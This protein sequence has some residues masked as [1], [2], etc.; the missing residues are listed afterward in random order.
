MRIFEDYDEDFVDFDFDLGEFGDFFWG[1]WGL[2]WGLRGWWKEEDDKDQRQWSVRKTQPKKR[3]QGKCPLNIEIRLWWSSWSLWFKFMM[4][5]MMTAIDIHRSRVWHKNEIK[6]QWVSEN[7]LRR[8]PIRW[9]RHNCKQSPILTIKRC[10]RRNEMVGVGKRRRWGAMCE[11]LSTE[12]VGTNNS[13]SIFTS[14]PPQSTLPRA[15]QPG[16]RKK[17]PSYAL[18]PTIFLLIGLWT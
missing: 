3:C 15:G 6:D 18:A 8:V 11:H 5:M 12:N 2:W 1:L 9:N 10:Q 7:L 17:K 13:P 14:H 4:F 16:K